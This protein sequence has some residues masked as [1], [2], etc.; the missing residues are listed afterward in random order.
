MA[1]ANYVTYGKPKVG[2]AISTAP[3]GTEL[4]KNA[5]DV[6]NVAFKNLG[7]ISD[8]GLTNSNKIETDAINA[9]GGDTVLTLQKGKEDTFSYKLIEAINVDVLK[10]IYGQDNVTGNLETGIT[11]KANSKPLDARSIVIDMIFKGGIVKRIVI[12][13]GEIAEVGEINYAD[14][15]AVGFEVTINAIPDEAGNTHYDYI[16]KGDK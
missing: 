8:D 2:G 14:E 3:I 11:V 16:Y 7:Y 13:C 1:N 10:E 9:W 6:L 12:P 15:E 5:K 4:P